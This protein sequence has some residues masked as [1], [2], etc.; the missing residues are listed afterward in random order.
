ML[1][2]VS[3]LLYLLFLGSCAYNEKIEYTI[4]QE[5][6]DIFPDLIDVTIPYEIAPLNFKLVNSDN[7][8]KVVIVNQQSDSIIVTGIKGYIDIP[9]YDWSSFLSSSKGDTLFVKVVECSESCNK[10]YRPFHMYVSNDSIDKNL[11]YR[12]IEPTYAHWNEIKIVQR[13]ISSFEEKTF[14]SNRETNN[15]CMNCHT[16]NDNRPDE[17]LIH[18]R[19]NNAGTI[20]VR[21]NK[22]VKLNTQSQN[23]ISH[24][25]Y[26]C[27]H[28]SG[29]IIAFSTNL[30]HMSFFANNPRLLEVYDT[31]S[32]II[33]YN[34][35]SNE[36]FTSP[37][38]ASSDKM[39]TFPIFS[40][41]GDKLYFCICDQPRVMPR[42]FRSIRYKLVA[43][44][45][46]PATHVLGNKI[47]Y[48]IDLDSVGMG[49]SLPSISPDGRYILCSKASCGCFFSWS[50]DSDL[51]L[52]DLQKNA[53][54]DVDRWNSDFADSFSAW[55][56]N[57]RWVI[58]SSRRIDG[59]YSYPY[60]AHID[61]CGK[62]GRPFLLP[63]KDVDYYNKTFKS[64]NMPKLI[65]G[66]IQISPKDIYK[67][68]CCKE[69]YC[70]QFD[71]KSYKPV[72][73]GIMMEHSNVN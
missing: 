70:V 59:L 57:S 53:F 61:S 64:F 52:F 51:C 72:N 36:I 5:Y 43:I 13:D 27:W 16:F 60:I 22:V 44:D 62:V 26:P 38:I 12:L 8:I 10:L 71:E 66:A 31:S 7:R 46:N 48:V 9:F 30:T 15:N 58:F 67:V 29:K 42:D 24:F 33:L 21:N 4:V 49:I 35:E 54:L 20:L 69:D 68:V 34:I 37:L 3:L 6:P 1:K 23:T 45:Y 11:V 47:Q 63:Q 40:P 73:N 32:D 18:F 17:F 41:L 25:V 28:P 19:K 14:L 56:S 65:K 39:E 55:S 50:P 2:I